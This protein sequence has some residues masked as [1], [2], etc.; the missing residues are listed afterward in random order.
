LVTA[1]KSS[2]PTWDTAESKRP[3]QVQAESQAR[4][5]S[6]APDVRRK[7][8]RKDIQLDVSLYSDSNFY[9][10]FTENLSDGG[11]F[12]ATHNLLKIGEKIDLTITMPNEKKV[13][14]H[15]IV[16]WLRV[17]NESS[18]APPGMGIQFLSLEGEDLIK[19]F[20]A[21]RAP[22]FYDDDE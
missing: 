10:G 3:S 7:F 13:I 8:E 15:G 21:A 4:L 11:V 22:L 16:R 20:L 18:D 19:D 1:V 6:Q 2:A 5:K 14:A 17:Y 9:A 12:I